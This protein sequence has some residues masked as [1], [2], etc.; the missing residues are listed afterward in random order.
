MMSISNDGSITT[1]PF[2]ITDMGQLNKFRTYSTKI[3]VSSKLYNH[4][5]YATTTKSNNRNAWN[6]IEERNVRSIFIAF[7]TSLQQ[8]IVYK[9]TFSL[10]YVII[11]LSLS[12]FCLMVNSFVLSLHCLP[13]S[14]S[15][16]LLV[17]F[18]SWPTGLE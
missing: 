8:A 9:F 7:Q 10:T 1:A 12:S 3:F 5:H 11:T 6:Y 15:N 13:F 17:L 18:V 14:P 2:I 4:V 16:F